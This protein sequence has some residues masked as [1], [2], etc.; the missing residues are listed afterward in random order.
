M[1]YLEK[2]ICGNLWKS[3]FGGDNFTFGKKFV[4]RIELLYWF[5]V[6]RIKL[7]YWFLPLSAL[8]QRNGAFYIDCVRQKLWPTSKRS[9]LLLQ[10]PYISAYILLQN[11]H[12]T[13]KSKLGILD[14]YVNDLNKNIL[15]IWD[16]RTTFDL[17]ASPMQRIVIGWHRVWW[18]GLSIDVLANLGL[19]V[20][21][22]NLVKTTINNPK[23]GSGLSRC[24]L[25][26]NW[27]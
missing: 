6:I 3:M 19:A 13:Y 22:R 14:K 21:K 24:V 2:F 17:G 4:I 1:Q 16:R 18:F 25:E 27:S 8:P 11:N 5:L 15:W 9:F 20:L 7:R 26:N 23:V 10:E 12:A